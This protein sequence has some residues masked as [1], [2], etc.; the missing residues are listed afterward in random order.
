MRRFVFDVRLMSERLKIIKK[1]LTFYSQPPFFISAQYS[2][3][4]R[5]ISFFS[6]KE[7]QFL[8]VHSRFN[9]EKA[10]HSS[11]AENQFSRGSLELRP[12]YDLDFLFVRSLFDFLFLTVHSLFNSI[13]LGISMSKSISIS[14][15]DRSISKSSSNESRL[16]SSSMSSSEKSRSN[17]SF[18]TASSPLHLF[19]T[20]SLDSSP[21]VQRLY[22]LFS[23]S[24]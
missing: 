21:T 11:T 14:S 3:L 5:K 20:C 17:V 23:L 15:S 24:F 19:V 12:C 10:L 18:F 22:A 1:R 6:G 16:K 2:F 8:L 9:R 7:L 4:V 13:S